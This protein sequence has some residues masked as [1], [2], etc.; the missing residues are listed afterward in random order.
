[1]SER[2]LVLKFYS[3]NL[4]VTHSSSGEIDD[5]MGIFIME[6]SQKLPCWDSMRSWSGKVDGWMPTNNRKVK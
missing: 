2:L 1:M 4:T 6:H 5:T 3:S